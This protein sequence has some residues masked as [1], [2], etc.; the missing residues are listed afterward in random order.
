MKKLFLSAIFALLLFGSCRSRADRLVVE[1]P[2]EP[3]TVRSPAPYTITDYKNKD[4][5]GIIPEWVSLW[6]DSGAYGVEKLD[7]YGD[8]YVFVARNEANSFNALN[9]WQDGFSAALDFPRLAAARIEERLAYAVD[10]P[11]QSYGAFYETLIRAASDFPWTG[12][13]RVDDFWILKSFPPGE[14]DAFVGDAYEDTIAAENI[15]SVGNVQETENWE[16]QILVTIDR[17]LF[18]SQL[19]LIFQIIDPN[20]PPSRD[21]RTTIDRVKERFFERF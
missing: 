4:R 14:E 20:P 8:R 6:L 19:D 13:V 16:F 10:D 1:P 12:A 17:S 5:G 2:W 3:E 21:Q 7:A 15:V 9:L 18:T 11:D